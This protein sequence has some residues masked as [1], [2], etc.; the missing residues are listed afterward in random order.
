MA[1]PQRFLPAQAYTDPQVHHWD[2]SGYAQRYWH[3]LTAG[4]ALPAGHS[5]ALT[6]LNQPLLLTR[7]DDG[8]PRAFHNRC[9]H[10][11]VAL[12]Q[13]RDGA[14]ACRRLI[15]PYHGWTYSLQGELLAAARE[16]GFDPPFQRQDWPLPSLACREDGP[17]IWVALTPAVTPLE[18]Q[19][20][21]VHQ[22]V[23]DLWRQPLHQVRIL[24]RTLR[25][26]W[27]IAHDNT[28]D[29][30]HVAVA[31]PTTLHREQG[32]VRDYVHHTTALVNLLVTPHADGGC[33]HTFGLPPWLH[34]ITWP[35]GRLALLE[36]LPLSLDSCC[37]QLRLFAPGADSD[38]P[39][40][41]ADAANTVWLKE[42]LAFLDEDQALVESAQR[43]Y[44][45]G[46]VP[47]PV[48]ALE[49]RILHWQEVYR[50][51]LP[52]ELTQSLSCWAYGG[53]SEANPPSPN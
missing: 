38:G 16:Q 49:Q 7:A 9:P 42:L 17:L 4:S 28:L 5:L 43:G 11:G 8:T 6:L 45:S 1:S 46:L 34:L 44:R 52:D 3:P 48:H 47:G 30:Y 13:E 50:R 32:P 35:D 2:C 20:D 25:C 18:Q 19:L 37:M 22:R 29:D 15:C 27:K 31:H 23:A 51:D 36:F 14:T 40:L 24:Q 21:L 26:N 10:R 41:P 39:G 12:Q 53:R 33:F